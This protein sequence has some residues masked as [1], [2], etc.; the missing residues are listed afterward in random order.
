MTK[1]RTP[2]TP[3][4]GNER[5]KDKVTILSIITLINSISIVLLAGALVLRILTGL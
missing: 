4:T 2:F 3:K 1:N 5:L